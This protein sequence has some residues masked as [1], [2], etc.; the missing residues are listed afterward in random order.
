VVT[1]FQVE[2]IYVQT[3]LQVDAFPAVQGRRPVAAVTS[4]HTLWLGNWVLFPNF[5]TLAS[6]PSDQ[7]QGLQHE[8]V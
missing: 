3:C 1:I 8:A 7:G 5:R 2:A 6:V 4:A